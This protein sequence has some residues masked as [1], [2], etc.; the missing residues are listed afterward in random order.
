VIVDLE[1]LSRPPRKRRR[2]AAVADWL[3][4][5]RATT[6]G[7]GADQPGA[8]GLGRTAAVICPVL[9]GVVAANASATGLVVLDEVRRAE[10]VADCR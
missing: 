6:S 4:S 3:R 10:T 7:V 2:G 9:T 1:D 5:A 8:A